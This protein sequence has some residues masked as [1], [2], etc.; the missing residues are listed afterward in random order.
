MSSTQESVSTAP[1]IKADRKQQAPAIWRFFASVKLGVLWLII[2][3]IL[4][5]I[6]T[7]IPQTTGSLESL[8][9]YLARIG[10]ERAELY[11]KLGLLNVYHAW[12]FN[13]VLALMCTSIVV[14]SIDRWPRI[15]REFDFDEPIPRDSRFRGGPFTRKWDLSGATN[16]LSGLQDLFRKYF[17]SPKVSH[18]GDDVILYSNR[19]R[20]TRVGVYFVHAGILITAGG[21]VLGNFLGFTAGQI[22]L[23]EGQARDTVTRIA[24]VTPQGE[25]N[26]FLDPMPFAVRCDDF[27]VEFYKDPRTGEL[28]NRPKLFQSELT[29]LKGGREVHS[30]HIEVNSPLRYGGYTFYQASYD[31][32]DPIFH[33]EAFDTQTGERIPV[34]ARKDE[35][36]KLVGAEHPYVVKFFEEHVQVDKKIT[37]PLGPSLTVKQT[38]PHGEELDRFM[39]LQHYPG[40]DNERGAAWAFTLT[41]IDVTRETVEEPII[42]LEAYHRESGARRELTVDLGEPINLEGDP[43]TYTIV[44]YDMMTLIDRDGDLGPAVSMVTLDDE[45]NELDRF[46]I[47]Q[48]YPGKDI[49]RQARHVLHLKKVERVFFTG[50]QVAKDPGVWIVWFG[51]ALMILGMAIAFS[52]SHRTSWLKITPQGVA[53]TAMVHKKRMAFEQKLDQFVEEFEEQFPA[54][55][56]QGKSKPASAPQ[57]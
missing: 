51:S 55:E 2:L 11:D 19:G 37:L 16:K 14:A 9:G 5:I 25:I 49:G 26:T 33:L 4:S 17:G 1:G 8:Q 45:G 54:A 53:F 56:R 34:V 57:E 23:R 38:G 13:L 31:E 50:L 22:F 39:V 43:S 48:H 28:S 10:P 46:G 36:F 44:G 3:A 32:A 12:W 40:F 29:I 47:F 35:P 18:V 15:K 21:A 42:H 24:E 20:W 30:E 52:L 7:I 6:G 27:T 41:G